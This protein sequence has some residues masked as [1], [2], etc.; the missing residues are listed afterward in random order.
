MTPPD[1]EVNR[2]LNE[3]E[4]RLASLEDIDEEAPD[5]EGEGQRSLRLAL[6]DFLRNDAVGNALTQLAKV[7][8]HWATLK[9]K[10][11]DAQKQLSLNA[12]RWGILF[13]CFLLTVLSIL[14]WNG[15]ITKELAA[16]LIGSLIG[17]WYGRDRGK[18]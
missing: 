4:E 3:I 10:E 9:T 5:V 18:G 13:S 17:Y 6:A 2:R 11:M 1:D 8:E 14:V 7:P 15:K 16:G 12:N